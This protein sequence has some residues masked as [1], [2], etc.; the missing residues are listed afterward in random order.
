M[1]QEVT[2]V[3]AAQLARP[4]A[5]VAL[6]G[7]SPDQ[8]SSVSSLRLEQE[9]GWCDPADPADKTELQNRVDEI[10][11]ENLNEADYTEESWQA[12]QNALAEAENVLDNPDATQEEI[13]NALDDLNDA[14]DGLEDSTPISAA[15][16]RTLVENF[17][18]E[19][20]FAN[21]EVPRSLLLH[22]TVVSQFEDQAAAEK[23][24]RHMESFKNLLAYQKNNEL[25]SEK[26]HNTLVNKADALIEK[27]Q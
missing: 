17:E 14:R 15:I 8:L 26:A 21:D 4:V 20:E 11:G 27:W 16:I 24:V 10:H 23:V 18:E 9:S 2:F 1:G 12:L 6:D 3:P 13:D 19:G 25:I 5:V 22:L 7:A